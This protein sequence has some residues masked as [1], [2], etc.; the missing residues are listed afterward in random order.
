MHYAIDLPH[1]YHFHNISVDATAPHVVLFYHNEAV[2]YITDAIIYHYKTTR[3]ILQNA[4]CNLLLFLVSANLAATQS[5]AQ[6]AVADFNIG[7]YI[8]EVISFH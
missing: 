1:E 5:A 2:W 7:H 3:L 4:I 8:N 6:S